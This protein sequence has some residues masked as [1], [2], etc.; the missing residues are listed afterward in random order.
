MVS[1]AMY[2]L[3]RQ[4]SLVSRWKPRAT[5]DVEDHLGVLNICMG[6]SERLSRCTNMGSIEL[7]NIHMG[8]NRFE[9]CN[10]R[11]ELGGAIGRTQ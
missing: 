4:R 10:V 9:Q 2:G 6:A 7:P 1:T 11:I 5:M 8:S 3:L